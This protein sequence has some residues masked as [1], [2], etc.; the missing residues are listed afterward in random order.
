MKG[1]LMATPFYA[2][3]AEANKRNAWENRG[4]FTLASDYGDAA[5]EAV[6]ARFGAVLADLSWH[7]RVQMTGS[8]VA[9]FAARFFTRDPAKLEPGA[10]L[11]AL[12]LNDAGGVRGMGTVV[13][14]GREAF[15]LAAPS[16][17]FDWLKQAARL[18]EVAVKDITAAEGVL[19]LVGPQSRKLMEL[20]GFEAE[21]PP[22]SLKKQFWRG[23]DITLSRFG[24]GYELWCEPDN[25]LILWDRLMTAGRSFA[26]RLAGQNAMD[27]LALESGV[28]RSGRDFRP[29][30][31]GFAPQPSAQALGLC[32]L[33]DRA[34][35]FNGSRAFLAAGA[36]TLLTG[37]LLDSETPAPDTDVMLDGRPVGRTLAS[38]Y[39][40]ALRQGVA[41]A[42]FA[43]PPPEH[44]LLAGP[45]KCRAAALPLLAFPDP[46][47]PTEN[48]PPNV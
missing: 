31:D 5:G 38:H 44:G 4:R 32:G 19:A 7:W 39:S 33:V 40:P 48:P 12:W 14:L 2:R 10:A 27:I 6:A 23:L 9:E 17:D 15:L 37:L 42:V 35:L 43:A 25:A 26:L 20:A 1:E 22:R 34:H 47:P 46:I 3:T 24:L 16:E 18:Y 36:D 8:R 21:M 41:L 30:R 13:R 11:E 45:A 28:L 29:T